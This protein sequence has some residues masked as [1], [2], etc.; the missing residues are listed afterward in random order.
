MRNILLET[1]WR[2]SW[3]MRALVGL[4]QQ[5]DALGTDLDDGLDQLEH[6]ETLVGLGYV[7]LQVYIRGAAE[8]LGKL[9]T[10]CPKL[11]ALRSGRCGVA[12]AA[13]IT[14]IEGVWAAANYFKH[15]DEWEDWERDAR[16]E[17]LTALKELGI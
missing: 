13:N 9:F 17:T 16:R 15:H 14:V 1:D 5:M 12:N 10:H 8:D 4:D 7:A 6:A 11:P 3:T 2:H